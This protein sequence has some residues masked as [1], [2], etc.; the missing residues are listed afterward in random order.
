MNISIPYQRQRAFH[1]VLI[2]LLCCN[3]SAL[4]AIELTGEL[5]RDTFIFYKSPA[6]QNQKDYSFSIA[7]TIF[8]YQQLSNNLSLN[9]ETFWRGDSKDQE[10]SH[11]DLRVAQLLYYTD[12]FEISAGL[13]R[14]FWGATEFVHLVDI[15]NQTDQVE[16]LD[17]E[18]KLGQPM[19]H[20][21]VTEKWGVV[22]TFFLPWFRERTFPGKNGRFR[23]QIPVNTKHSVYE[24]CAEQQ[25]FDFALRYST[26]FTNTDLAFSYFNGTARE[27][28]LRYAQIEST[29]EIYPYYQQ[30]RQTG[31]DLQMATGAWL[32]KAEAYY[33][34]GQGKPY[35]A[36]T[37]GFEYTFVRIAN[38]MIDA[39]VLGEYVFDNRDQSVLPTMY[40]NDL[41]AGIR[42]A[43]NDIDDSTLLLGVTYDLDNDST[44]V[45]IEA[46]RR[47]NSSFRLNLESSFF[48]G[49]DKKDPLYNV[50][51]DDYIKF[52]LV[53]YW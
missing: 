39:G 29:T 21:T 50:S 5:S 9:F 19:L 43:L 41:M 14:V 36:T 12:Y 53:Y 17:G 3:S 44:V 4:M 24:S 22:E 18:Q 6:W 11:T 27:P 7:A 31:L 28:E 46:S 16:A 26:T 8:Y 47:L 13:D 42:L 48:L 20:C 49:T 32:L 30:I 2:V 34:R 15:I 37:F 45:A 1:I 40:D 33:R 25:H 38:T 51:R 35:P 23:T 10:R 52:E